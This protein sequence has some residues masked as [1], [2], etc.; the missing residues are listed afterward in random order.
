M[1]WAIPHVTPGQR[2]ER[3]LQLTTASQISEAAQRQ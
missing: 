1:D 3:L 2:R